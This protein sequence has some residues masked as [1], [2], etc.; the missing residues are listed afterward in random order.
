[1]KDCVKSSDIIVIATP[2]PEFADIENFLKDKIV[3]DCW[4]IID[5]K[6]LV[7]VNYLAIGI[8]NLRK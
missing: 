6:K 8:G 3:V 7:N 4:R 1:M 5:K 2:W